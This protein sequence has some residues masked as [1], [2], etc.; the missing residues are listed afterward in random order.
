[1]R[2]VREARI[3]LVPIT[4]DILDI[5]NQIRT[6]LFS[7]LFTMLVEAVEGRMT[8]AEFG[9][10]VQQKMLMLGP[11]VQSLNTELLDPLLEM[12]YENL[13][14]GGAI[15]R[16]RLRWRNATSNR[17]SWASWR[18]RSRRAARLPPNAW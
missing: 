4:Q 11:V 13:L 6:A 8:A 3:D 12:I 14:E 17:S 5:R 1:M 7:D 16:R 10:R 2:P 18:R 15:L 9:M